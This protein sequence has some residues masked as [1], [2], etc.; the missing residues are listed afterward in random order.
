MLPVDE[1][2]R[3]DKLLSFNF[4]EIEKEEEFKD[5]Y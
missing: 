2:S 4:N 3:T 5:I 1:R